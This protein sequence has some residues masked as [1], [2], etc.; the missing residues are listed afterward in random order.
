MPDDGFSGRTVSRGELERL[1]AL[2]DRYEFAFDPCSQE[3]KEAES[4]FNNSV[5]EM[6]ERHV[7]PQ[8]AS[9]NYQVF[10]AKIRTLCRDFLRKERK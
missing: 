4:S 3:A 6:F 7:K 2:F 9:V 8:A 5:R 10:H 1:A